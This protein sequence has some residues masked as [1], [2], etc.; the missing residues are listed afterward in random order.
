MKQNFW[1][2]GHKPTL[3]SAFLYFDLSFM[4]WVLLGPLAV[5]I[6]GDLALTPAQKGMMVA[7]PVLT[8][9]LLR[10]VMGI[11]VDQIQ[12]KKAGIIG[13]VIVIAALA[14]AWLNGIHSYQQA[15]VLGVFLGV[16]GASFAVAL[17]L[18]SRWYPPEH[19]GTALGIAGAGNSGTALAALFAPG[20]AL[21]FGWNNVFGLALIPLVI[22]LVLYSL[23]AKDAPNPPASKSLVEYL[24]VLKDKDAW[25]FMFFYSVTFGGFVGMASSLT[26]YFNDQYGLDAVHAGYFTAAC[27]FAGS[28]VRPIGGNLADRLGGIRTLSVMYII[29]ASFLFILSLGL[30]AQLSGL[31]VVICA[32]MAMGMGNGAV[33]QLVPQRFRKEIGVMTGLIGMAGG[34]GGFYLASSLGY[35]KQLTGSYQ[36]GLIMFAILAVIALVGLTFVKQRWRTTWGSAAVTSAKI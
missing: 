7:T 36:F 32:M 8:G 24:N 27:V 9:A 16:A 31:L 18:A 33:F 2:A 22:T 4:V 14:F 23:L 1:Q 30:K 29:A 25:W 20:L 26:I 3:F 12:P 6:A 34:I 28:L 19:Q 5:Q 10:M 35:S 15:L 11:L 17:P 21:A 13:Q